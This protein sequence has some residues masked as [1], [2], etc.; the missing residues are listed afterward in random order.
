MNRTQ[1]LKTKKGARPASVASKEPPK[2]VKP[3]KNWMRF[4]PCATGVLFAIVIYI[5]LYSEL[6]DFFFRSQELSLFLPGSL[7]FTQQMAL[8]GGFITWVSAFL[9]QFF[10]YPWLGILLLVSLWTFMYWATVRLFRLAPQWALLALVLPL[11]CMAV[12]ANVGYWLFHLKT[13]GF[14]YCATLGFLSSLLIIA[15]YRVIPSRFRVYWAVVAVFGGYALFGYYALLAA[16]CMVVDFV[17]TEHLLVR[18][19]AQPFVLL[20]VAAITPVVWYYVYTQINFNDIYLALL[21]VYIDPDIDF[22]QWIPYIVCSVVFC[23]LPLIA[24]KG[25][26]GKEQKGLFYTRYKIVYWGVQVLIG[27]ALFYG[28]KTYWYNDPNYRAELFMNRASLVGNWDAVIERA[29]QEEQEPTRLMVM[30]KNLALF[31]QGRVGDEMFRFPDGGAKP[32][33]KFDERMLQVGGKQIYMN[34]AKLN[35]CYRWCLE[36]AVEYGMKVE[37]IKYMIQCSILSGDNNLA[38][39]YIRTLKKTLFHAKWAEEQEKFLNDPSLIRKNPLYRDIT[40][41]LVYEDYLDGDMSLA[42]IYLLNVFS[43]TWSD[44]PLYQ[45]MSM[46]STLVMK[47]IPLFWPRFIEYAQTHQRIPVHYQEAAVLYC[48]LEHQYDPNQLPIDESVMQRFQRFQ[49]LINQNPGKSEDMLRP[50]FKTQFGDTFWYF[51]FFVRNVKSN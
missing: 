25:V 24:K 42:E 35:F 13:V 51:Y 5:C 6:Q 16:V 45:E 18:R 48:Y 39:R 32:N 29:H 2:A 43:H 4:Y 22:M 3:G 40:K 17:W 19:I 49:D 14:M 26:D 33:A 38:R 8:P 20:L 21:P 41:L 36:D 7:F 15:V 50:L 34:Y 37:Y 31:R 28:V 47:D 10:Y 1:N 46:A 30:L 12:L 27:V 11:G 9:T 44:E 23:L